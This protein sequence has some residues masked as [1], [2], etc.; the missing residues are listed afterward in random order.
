MTV[1]KGKSVTLFCNAS[2]TPVPSVY[3]IHVSTGKQ[4]LNRTWVL[5]DI[6]VDDLGEYKCHASNKFGNDSKSVSIYFAG[7]CAVQYLGMFLVLRKILVHAVICIVFTFKK[8][9]LYNLTLHVFIIITWLVCTLR[10][11]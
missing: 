2:G 7:K 10:W 3:W 8:K 9:L 5:T 4:R 6:K 1:E 11:Y